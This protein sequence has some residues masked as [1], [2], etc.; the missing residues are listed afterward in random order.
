MT[1]KITILLHGLGRTKSI[2]APIE[3]ALI[4]KNIPVFNVSYPSTQYPIAV[5]A[6]IISDELNHKFPGYSFDFIT[7]S[8]GSIILR[9]MDAHK[10]ISHIHRVVMI[11]PPNQGT[12]IIN[13]LRH[14]PSFRSILG[15]AALELATDEA[16][17]YH[18]LP[19]AVNF[20][21]GII[22]G[23]KSID[24][25]FSWTL[26][27]G[28]D[29]GK[30]SVASTKITSMADHT[31]VPTTHG[32]LPGKQETIEQALYFLEHG[33]FNAPKNTFPLSRE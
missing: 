28:A 21:C 13:F 8:L 18:Q 2:M 16:G 33:K 1:K 31:I 4:K 14:I 11:G 5:L 12:A 29:D 24:P 6:K 15:P 3:K 26:L 10:L 32:F 19:Q 27:K 20:S 23:N 25:W 7:H 9:Y 22:A 17:I 30:V